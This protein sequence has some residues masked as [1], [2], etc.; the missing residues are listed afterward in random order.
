MLFWT[1]VRL[2][3]GF[4]V[5][6]SPSVLAS[7]KTNSDTFRNFRVIF[8]S[9]ISVTQI[10]MEILLGDIDWERFFIS[11]N[12]IS[13]FLENFH[14]VFF[15]ISYTWFTHTIILNQRID[16][17]FSEDKLIR[18]DSSFLNCSSYQMKIENFFLLE[19]S[20]TW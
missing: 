4:N 18:F 5:S 7:S 8:F 2:F 16:N 13:N 19:I 3:K 14:N 17:T 9:V 20:V 6:K 15:Q 12:F 11:D 10:F 1:Q